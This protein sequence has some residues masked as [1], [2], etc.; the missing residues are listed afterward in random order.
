[1]SSLLARTG[2]KLGR[3]RRSPAAAD[4]DDR[5]E[6]KRGLLVGLVSGLAAIGCCVSPVVLVLLGV[7]T[8]VEAMALRDTLYYTYG[9]AFRGAGLVIALIAV[10]YYLRGRKVCN[11]RGARGSWRLLAALVLSGGATY[12]GL[13]WFTKLLAIWSES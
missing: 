4:G 11:L 8:S 12:A 5:R 9:W 6:L 13:F 2:E 3:S 1:M 10:V 7:A